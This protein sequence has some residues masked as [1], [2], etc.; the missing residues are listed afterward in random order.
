MKNKVSIG[1]ALALAASEAL[2]QSGAPSATSNQLDAVVISAERSRQTTFDA[3]AAISA[4]TR[5]TLEAAGPGVNLSEALSRVPGITVLNRQNYAQDLQ[6]S[7]RGF[8]SRSTFGIRGVRL[9]VD[10]IPA[11]MPDGQGQ[12]SNVALS[13]AGRIEVLRG[14]LA[15]LY[16]N[17]AGGVVQVFTDMEAERPTTTVSGSV[18]PYGQNKV[19]LKF[20]AAG[21]NDAVVL[22]VSTFHTD[23]FRPHSKATRE[24]INGKWQHDFGAGSRFSLVINSLDQPVSLD[25]LGLNAAQFR[26]GAPG[27]AFY[28]AAL[29]QDPRKTVLQQQIGGV[30][31]QRLGP[32]TQLTAR[33]YFG[34]RDLDNALSI[35]RPPSTAQTFTTASGGIV[36]FSRS[37]Q[38]LGLQLS[39]ALKFDNGQALRLVGGVDLDESDEDRQGYINDLGVRGALKRDE[40]N[41]SDNRDAFVQASYEMDPQWTA[42]AGVRASRVKFRSQDFFTAPVNPAIAGDLPNPDD[43]GSLSF[44]ATSPVLGLSWRATPTL[45]AYA[46]V[47]QGFE[48]PTFTELSYRPVGTGLNTDLKASKSRHAEIGAKW[49]YAGSQR[50][51]VALFDI[52]TRD[53]IVVDTNLNGR[54]TFKNAGRT[55]RRGIEFSHGGQLGEDLRT[56]VSLTVLRARFDDAFVSGSGAT[57]VSIAAGNRL[58]GTPERSAFAELAWSPRGAW[59]GFNSGVEVVHT[60]K[61]YVNDRNS[62]AAPAAT[63]LN[64]RAGFQQTL[65][66]WQFSQL[67]RVDNVA[68]R[69]YAGSV[70]VNEGNS[71]FFEPA[72]PRNWLVGLKARYEFR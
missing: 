37:Y 16:G 44:S 5:E 30:L 68:D 42:T 21:P 46:N 35:P 50:L 25:P 61:L 19:G 39:H 71:R 58:P 54:S 24:Q 18:G 59:G 9:I 72:M 60:G 12:A 33:L 55:S 57:A 17:A 8:G 14:P 53:E 40:R 2:A 36:V 3:P 38:G 67:L 15:Q 13:S 48:T 23:G 65:G 4:V 66:E 51:D 69:K 20:A 10:G 34:Q 47:G 11:T 22:D 26:D 62:D 70:I 6:L 32:D 31:E 28:V 27:N 45:N 64:L 7:I 49:K 1:G 63:V 41:R 56:T 52:A 43:S 29:A